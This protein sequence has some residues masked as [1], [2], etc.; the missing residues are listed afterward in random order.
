MEG[1]ATGPRNVNWRPTEPA[2]LVWAEALDG[3]D[4]KKKALMRDRV[5]MLKA[6]FTGQPVELAKTEFRFAGL[7]WLEKGGQVFLRDSDRVS[8]RARTFLLN[9]DNSTQQAKLIWNRSA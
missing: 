4:T 3:G 8:R 5:V 7:S 6:P 2:T 1:V 9:A